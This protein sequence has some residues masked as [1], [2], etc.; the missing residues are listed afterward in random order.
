MRISP[1][2]MRIR[3]ANTRFGNDVG[4]LVDL[5]AIRKANNFAISK[6]IAFVVPLDD[7][8]SGN[9]HD[10]TID[11]TLKEAFSVIVIFA[12]DDAQDDK[13]GVLSYDKIHD[14]RSELFR[15]LVGWE[16]YFARGKIQYDGG[17]LLPVNPSYLWYQYS[18]SFEVQL[19]EYDGYCDIH[20]GTEDLNSTA[21]NMEGELRD[22]TQ[23]SQ[24]DSL[25]EIY[26]D[27]ILSP[28]GNIPYTGDLPPST[29]LVDMSQIV[30]INDD[31][32]PGSY[33][34]GFA[35]G[36]DFYRILNRKNDPK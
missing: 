7:S 16:V 4:S 29:S 30:T 15:A 21:P 35:G 25:L 24:L 8:V 22:W 11:Q 10:G 3:A 32:N 18:F 19:R 20:K 17:R 26:T 34:R 28:S 12:N 31:P 13:H 1:L 27:Y 23:E 33:D 9:S 5:D 2:V 6:D 14:T 36:F